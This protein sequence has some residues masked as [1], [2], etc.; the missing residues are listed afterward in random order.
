MKPLVLALSGTD[1]HPFERM[2]SWIDL[3][4]SRHPDLRFVVQHGTAA[5]PAVAE[6]RD[7][8]AHDEMVDLIAQ[9]LLVEIG[10]AHV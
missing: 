4:A 7:Y 2:V 6:G 3:A 1:H 5:P 10:R 9:A 8:L